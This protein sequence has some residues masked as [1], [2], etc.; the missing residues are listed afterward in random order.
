MDLGDRRRI[1]TVKRYNIDLSDGNWSPVYFFD[2]YEL[3]GIVE[4]V[5]VVTSFTPVLLKFIKHDMT[6]SDEIYIPEYTDVMLDILARGVKAKSDAGGYQQFIAGLGSDFTLQQGYSQL[7]PFSELETHITPEFDAERH[8]FVVRKQG[9]RDVKAQIRFENYGESGANVS[10]LIYN[11]GRLIAQVFD[12]VPEGGIKIVTTD[13]YTIRVA[14][15][16]EIYVRAYTNR[17]VTIKAGDDT[18]LL[19]ILKPNVIVEGYVRGT[20]MVETSPVSVGFI[21]TYSGEGT[22][23]G[24][25]ERRVSYPGVFKDWYLEWDTYNSEAN[26]KVT[27]TANMKYSMRIRFVSTTNNRVTV[28]IY[29]NGTQIYSKYYQFGWDLEKVIS[30]TISGVSLSEG[31]KI[32]MTI[33][34]EQAG[35]LL[36]AYW[37]V[38]TNI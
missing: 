19:Y 12:Y 20:T 23:Q 9:I 31:D 28:T 34:P 21:V 15:D 3:K 36:N 11:S 2:N 33:Y 5:R 13:T 18:Q 26:I 24:Y 37:E 16:D 35:T 17:Q 4:Q 30:D 32:W 6:E 1:V 8:S 10:V 29:K 7:I 25:Q 27:R 14:R 38:L 22:F